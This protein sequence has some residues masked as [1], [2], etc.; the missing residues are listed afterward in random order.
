MTVDRDPTAAPELRGL[1]PTRKPW[2]TPRV[3]LSEMRDSAK[4]I[5]HSTPDYHYSGT[6]SNGS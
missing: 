5:P 4:L 1:G 2:A 3:I 6:D